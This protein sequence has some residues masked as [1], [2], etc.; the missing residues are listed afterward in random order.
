MTCEVVVLYFAKSCELAGVRSENVTVPQETTTRQ[1]WEEIT[2]LHPRL[3]SI[4]D[5]V[6]LAIR[7]EYVAIGDEAISLRPGDEVAIIPPISGG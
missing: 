6:V 3:C 5:H 2:S 7:Q 4:Q 1:L